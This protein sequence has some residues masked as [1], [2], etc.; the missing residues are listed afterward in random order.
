VNLCFWTQH[1][2]LHDFAFHLTKEANTVFLTR[3]TWWKVKYTCNS[4]NKPAWKPLETLFK[5]L[6]CWMFK[7]GVTQTFRN[8]QSAKVTMMPTLMYSILFYSTICLT[9]Y[10]FNSLRN[11]CDVASYN[12]ETAA[13][14]CTW[15]RMQYL[16]ASNTNLVVMRTWYTTIFDT[17]QI[18]VRQPG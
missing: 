13:R 1:S 11:T 6:G 9:Q 2:W 15:F 16:F 17:T 3:I 12:N 5:V 7:L 4:N 10:L 14:L 8:G 18:P